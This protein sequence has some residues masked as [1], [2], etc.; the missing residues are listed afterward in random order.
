V[1][2]LYSRIVWNEF[3]IKALKIKID[4]GVTVYDFPFL[5]TPCAQCN[6]Q[7]CV[8]LHDLCLLVRKKIDPIKKPMLL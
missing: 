1:G 4:I 3:L 8:S 2:D 5:D 6:Y 7:V